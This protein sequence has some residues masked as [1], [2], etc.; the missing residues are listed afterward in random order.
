MIFEEKTEIVDGCEV[1]FQII[2]LTDSYYIYIGDKQQ[3]FN[4]FFYSIQTK[5]VLDFKKMNEI[6]K[7]QNL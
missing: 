3:N 1:I 4:N 5:Y 7:N 6:N 2:K